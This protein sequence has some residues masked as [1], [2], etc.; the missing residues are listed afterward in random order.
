M[1]IGKFCVH[2]ISDGATKADGDDPFAALKALMEAD[3]RN[4]VPRQTRAT[5]RG[6]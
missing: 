5:G 3:R 6:S 1:K 4:R 2:F